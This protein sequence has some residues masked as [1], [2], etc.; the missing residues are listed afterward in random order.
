MIKSLIIKYVRIV[1]NKKKTLHCI[2][3]A[4]KIDKL[5]TRNDSPCF[6]KVC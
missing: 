5:A 6:M 4:S 3:D 2:D 1:N